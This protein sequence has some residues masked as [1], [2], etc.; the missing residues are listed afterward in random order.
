MPWDLD[1]N[2]KNSIC[3]LGINDCNKNL[4]KALFIHKML[5][6]CDGHMLLEIGIEPPTLWLT[7][8]HSNQLNFSS[9]HHSIGQRSIH[10]ELNPGPLLGRPL[11]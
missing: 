7:T 8:T 1:Q 11:C 9:Y 2:S 4:E 3:P 5:K 6:R 10:W